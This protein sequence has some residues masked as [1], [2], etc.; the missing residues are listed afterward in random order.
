M[1]KEFKQELPKWYEDLSDKKLILTNDIDSLLSCYVLGLSQGCEIQ[2][3]YSFKE[4]YFTNPKD[5]TGY[6]GVDLDAVRPKAK[7]FGNHVTYFENDNAISLNRG[8]TRANYSKKFAGSTLIT[9]MSLYDYDLKEFT[10][11]QL[12][13]LISIDT[14]FKQYFFSSSTFKRYYADILEY[15]EFI[16]IV[17]SHSKGYF[18]NIINKYKLYEQITIKDGYLHTKIDL[19]G[20]SNLFN[21]DLRLPQK[22]FTLIKKFDD[23]GLNLNE[24]NLK[25]L[26][27]KK[28]KIFSSALVNKNFLKVSVS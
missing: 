9:I 11:E 7:I 26:E 24:I 15:P 14:A 16:D 3:F 21:I 20:L 18:Y 22:K 13:V 17:K 10:T 27:S 8:I 19:E 1:K 2:G 25:D 6:I 28:H 4:M 5:N 23:Y 12:E